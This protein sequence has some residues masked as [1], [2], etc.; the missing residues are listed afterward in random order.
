MQY[1]SRPGIIR[2]RINEL[3]FCAWGA[4]FCQKISPFRISFPM[5]KTE[6]SD[7]KHDELVSFAVMNLV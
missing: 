4:V 5:R 3:L 1:R 2:G 7:D 6:Q